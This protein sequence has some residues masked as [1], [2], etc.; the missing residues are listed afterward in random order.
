MLSISKI[1]LNS[2]I[3]SLT[4]SCSQYKTTIVESN[5]VIDTSKNEN[6]PVIQSSPS[7]SP[8]STPTS[9]PEKVEI[10]VSPV[11]EMEDIPDLNTFTLVESEILAKQSII[12]DLNRH[13]DKI[14]ALNFVEIS[15][16]AKKEMEVYKLKDT[17]SENISIEQNYNNST[18]KLVKVKIDQLPSH[19]PLVKRFLYAYNLYDDRNNLKNIYITIQ[20]YVEE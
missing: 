12:T 9:M 2:L 17:F 18:G 8:E 14:E 19:S 1:I 20:G 13:R 5:K 3:L 15:K 10:K 7:S 11:L 4:F 16:W 6:K